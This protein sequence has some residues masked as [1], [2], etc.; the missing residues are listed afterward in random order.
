MTQDDMSYHANEV[1]I[2]H[3]VDGDVFDKTGDN[4]SWTSVFTKIN[5]LGEHVSKRPQNHLQ[6]HNSPQHKD[7]QHQ[8]AP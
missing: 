4:S 1:L 2:P 7:R 3:L 5:L 6:R 8:D